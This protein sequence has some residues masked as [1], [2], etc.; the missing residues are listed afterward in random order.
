MT[1]LI[2]TEKPSS[3]EKIASALAEGPIKK[4]T[5]FGV[6]YYKIKRCGK[7]L[8]VAP[9][10][11]HLFVLAEAKKKGWNYPVF[12]TAWKPVFSVHKS[13]GWSKKYFLNLEKLAGQATDFISA[14]DFDVEGSVIAW[15][16][17]RFIC[18]TEKGKRMK[19][20]TLTPTDLAEAYDYA[21]K[22]LDFEQIEAGLARHH[23]DFLWGIN[24]SRALIMALKAAGSFKILSTGRVQGPTLELLEKREREIAV[25]VP[26]PFW[27]LQL[28]AIIGKDEVLASHEKGK[29]WKKPEAET[30]HK[31]C[32]GKPGSVK[33]VDKREYK[34]S[35]PTPFDLPSLQREAYK[36]FGYSPKQTL[37][38]AQT[39]YEQALISYPR[40][41]SQKLPAKLGLKE[42]IATIGK[43]K[44]YKEL[45][46]ELL[47]KLLIP[48]EGSKEDPAHPA[49]YPTGH[50]PGNL[51]SYQKKVYDLVVRRFLAVFAPAA[52]R[53]RL[54][55]IIDIEGEEFHAEGFRTLTANWIAF[56]GPY[57]A[58]KEVL[59]PAVS[60]GETIENKALDLLD[61]ETQPPP[62]LTQATILK[63]MEKRGLGTKATRAGILQTLYDRGY[64][65]D[66]SI[67]VTKLGQAVIQSLERHSHEI[68]S[69]ELTRKFEEDMEAI[70]SGKKKR[71]TVIKEA[72]ETLERILIGFKGNEKKIGAFLL[73]ALK[74]V[75]KT[76]STIGLCTCKNTL[77]I[78]RSRAGK[79]FVGCLGYPKCRETFS[80]PHK[81]TVKPSKEKC[82]TC[83]LFIVA[84]KAPGK[85]PWKL[86][87]RDG[88]VDKRPSGKPA[89]PASKKAS[90]KPAKKS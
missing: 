63:E 76:E 27:E 43:Q 83:G 80:L 46:A 71:E 51:N 53:E 41:A 32:S 8:L 10:V 87:V 74:D 57:A 19:F 90:K 42:I 34:Q 47:K 6:A 21:S 60:K 79:R 33:G 1:T 62:R 84:V 12:E 16:I 31:K 81:G 85:R 49:I 15:N 13:S 89:K 23:L 29:F 65:D 75:R 88:F 35:P 3:S 4:A 9:A 78:R 2:V 52:V 25:F 55:L 44:V 22:Q 70:A 5:N 28:T 26:T 67:V 50:F 58:F 64:I 77:V 36:H 73:E 54:K 72:E 30:I 37:D 61:K 38:I 20:S 68:V 24:A 39:L 86:C 56:Y 14:C 18:K 59:L 40:T 82:I 45:A 69:V 11:G 7:T 48:H 66:K 17:L